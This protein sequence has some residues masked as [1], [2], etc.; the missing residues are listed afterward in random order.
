[1]SAVLDVSRPTPLRLLGFL[2][3]AVGGVL[4]AWGAISDWATIVFLGAGFR[5]SATPGVDVVEGQVALA[6]GVFM[7]VSIVALRLATGTAARRSV[8]LAIC[9]AAAASLAIGVVDLVRAE[10]RFGDY[11]VEEIAADVARQQR[12]PI[13]EARRAVQAVVNDDGSIDVGPG[14][15]LVI[16]GGALGLVGGLLDL[17]WVGQ[18]RLREAEGLEP[19][20]G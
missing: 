12:V 20:E 6:L 9:V 11:A 8:A 15:W 18:Q 13:A 10:E 4:I 3:T 16:A 7:L 14:L 19:A 2:F 1:M 17:A 5:D